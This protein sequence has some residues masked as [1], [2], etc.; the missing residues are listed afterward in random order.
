M[1]I[2]CSVYVLNCH[3]IFLD[4]VRTSHLV[5]TME[6]KIYLDFRSPIF[7]LL[8]VL[9][10]EVQS[11]KILFLLP[12]AT[13]SETHLFVPLAKE[14]LKRGHDI[15]YVS[16]L[17]AT[18]GRGSPKDVEILPP[19]DAGAWGISNPPVARKLNSNINI[20][21]FLLVL[22]PTF[23]YEG[24]RAVFE[25]TEFQRILQQESFDL[26]IIN[27]DFNNCLFGVVHKF[28]APYILLS[29]LPVFREL[30][31]VTGLYL[32]PSFVP[33]P[34][35]ISTDKMTFIQ[36]FQNTIVE[37]IFS[38]SHDFFFAPECEKVYRHYLGEDT[39]S[40]LEIEWNVSMIFSNSFYGVTSPR[41]MTPDIVEVGGI[42]CREPKSLSKVVTS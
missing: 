9:V 15:T 1:T 17:N 2:V 13:R 30:A 42:H 6:S 35:S 29:S 18:L 25:H 41:P 36:R 21:K 7:F 20:L 24:C 11:A 38:V 26:V 10:A 40:L 5:S 3:I 33:N 27:G 32:P 31:R 14:L 37:W 23:M 12:L 22:D 4:C 28:Q 19:I 39:P 34:W 8:L 16:P